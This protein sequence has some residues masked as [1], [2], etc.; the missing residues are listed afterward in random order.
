MLAAGQLDVKF[1][2]ASMVVSSLDN[3][4]G[5]YQPDAGSLAVAVEAFE[6]AEICVRPD[7]VHRLD[8]DTP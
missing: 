4:S 6:A 7:A 5:H 8:F 3:M 1:E 2:G